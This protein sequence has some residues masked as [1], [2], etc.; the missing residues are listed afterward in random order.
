MCGITGIFN[1]DRGPVAPTEIKKMTDVISHRG[2][3][4]EGIFIDG[5]IGLGHRRLSVIDLS[6]AAHQ[7]ME[8]SDCVVVYNGEIYNFKLLR[9]VLESYGYV[10]KSNTDTEIILHAY[11]E[12]GIDC[13]HKF[14]GMFAFALWD[15]LNKK[16]F[17][18]RDKYGIKPL[19]FYSDDNILVFGSEIKSIIQ[20]PKIKA[21]VDYY[22]MNEYFTFQNVFSDRTLFKGIRLLPHGC[23]IEISNKYLGVK[24]Y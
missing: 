23:Y 15:K 8:G 22:A 12:W 7:P 17:L 24:R 14:N 10:F 6:G 20:H 16:L 4:D 13:I 1:L 19:Y 21:D 2:P 9:T 5:Y 18:V 11:R 3:D